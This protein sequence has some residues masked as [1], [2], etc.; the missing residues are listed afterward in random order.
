MICVIS[1]I[2]D[3]VSPV[4]KILLSYFYTTTKSSGLIYFIDHDRGGALKS[5]PRQ[6]DG[7]M[8]FYS[9]TLDG[10][11]RVEYKYSTSC[12]GLILLTDFTLL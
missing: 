11:V 6:T 1:C 8:Q 3:R 12:N 9:E 7:P 10:T 5:C 4:C 2:I